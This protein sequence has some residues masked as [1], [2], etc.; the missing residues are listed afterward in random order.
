MSCIIQLPHYKQ[1]LR[2]GSVLGQIGLQGPDT[3]LASPV[4]LMKPSLE[5]RLSVWMEGFDSSGL[6]MS[7]VA[8]TCVHAHTINNV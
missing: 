2:A 3:P 8:F 7:L 1:P 4:I 6:P 5:T